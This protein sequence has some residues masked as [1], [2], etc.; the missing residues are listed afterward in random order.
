MRYIFE[1]I[2]PEINQYF[3][4][5]NTDGTPFSREERSLVYQ[6]SKKVTETP[7]L[8]ELKETFTKKVMNTFRTRWKKLCKTLPCFHF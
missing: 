3:I 8:L 5:S 6:R 2:R 7:F 4:E 1:I